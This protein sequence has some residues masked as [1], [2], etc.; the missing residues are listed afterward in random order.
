MLAVVLH[1]LVRR[2]TWKREVAR[3][4][5][6]LKIQAWRMADT[7]N[8]RRVYFECYSNNPQHC[9]E[10]ERENSELKAKLSAQKKYVRAANRG[11]ERNSIVSQMLAARLA[12]RNQQPPNAELSEPPTK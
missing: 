1:G 4:E 6:K 7:E 11:A 2:L 3:M 5:A 12:L 10:L 8:E 9:A